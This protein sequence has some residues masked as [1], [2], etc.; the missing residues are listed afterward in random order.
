MYEAPPCERPAVK[1]PQR[2]VEDNIYLGNSTRL[3]LAQLQHRCLTTSHHESH[4]VSNVTLLVAT[5]LCRKDPQRSC[6]TEAGCSS[7]Q[8]SQMAKQ[9]RQSPGNYSSTVPLNVRGFT[10]LLVKYRFLQVIW[11]SLTL[12]LDRFTL[13]YLTPVIQTQP[14]QHGAEQFHIHPNSKKRESFIYIHQPLSGLYVRKLLIYTY[15]CVSL[16]A[17][18]IDRNEKPGR[19]MIV[20]LPHRSA[21]LQSPAPASVIEEGNDSYQYKQTVYQQINVQMRHNET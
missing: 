13:N 6:S 7:T 12:L 21:P 10:T 17:P 9:H 11:S 1:V 20:P 2:Q 5:C 3:S 15:F 18:E 19:K 14:S 4:F 16:K 8:T